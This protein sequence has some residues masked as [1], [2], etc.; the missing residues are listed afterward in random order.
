M[1]YA[2][3]LQCYM[4]NMFFKNHTYKS[5]NILM[6]LLSLVLISNLFKKAYSYLVGSLLLYDCIL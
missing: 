3:S 1:L 2:L 6:V 5:L 4:S